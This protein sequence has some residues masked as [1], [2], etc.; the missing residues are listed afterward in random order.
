MEYEFLKTLWLLRFEKLRKLEEE[1]AWAYQDLYDQC[2]VALG[3]EHEIVRTLQQLVKEERNHEK[4]AEELIRI[5]KESYSG[6][7]DIF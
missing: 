5:C 1:S 7:N 3:S 4:L 6:E 2:L